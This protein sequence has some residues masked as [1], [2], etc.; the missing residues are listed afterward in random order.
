MVAEDFAASARRE[1]S[2]W[3]A[4][5]ST[6]ER[7]EGVVAQRPNNAAIAAK[8][9]RGPYQWGNENQLL[10]E[11]GACNLLLSFSGA[12]AFFRDVRIIRLSV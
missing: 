2:E 6:T 4:P 9:P 3:R 1:E 11:V 8:D 5:A 12:G 10:V 7:S